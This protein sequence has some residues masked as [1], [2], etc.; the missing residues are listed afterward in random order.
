MSANPTPS[1]DDIPYAS[2][3]QQQL[4]LLNQAVD[5]LNN[6][7]VIDYLTV[8]PAPAPPPVGGSQPMP[9]TPAM[10]VRVNLDPPVSDA[11]TVANVAA[12]LQKQADAIT[13]QLATMGY[14]PSSR[15]KSR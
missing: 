2:Q 9:S 7:G 10:Q 3:L 13:Q 12:A 5:V 1:V 6:S 14:A 15:S 4:A 8:S 11:T